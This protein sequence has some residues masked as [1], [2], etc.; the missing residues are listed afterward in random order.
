MQIKI[1]LS[2][3]SAQLAFCA[4]VYPLSC[5]TVSDIS[6]INPGGPKRPAPITPIDPVPPIGGCH[7]PVCKPGEACPDYRC[8]DPQPIVEPL[9]T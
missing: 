2:L 3:I 5:G 4:P 9:E 8:A 6:I 1:F 7:N